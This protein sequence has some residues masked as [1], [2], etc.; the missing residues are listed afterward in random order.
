MKRFKFKLCKYCDSGNIKKRGFRKTKSD[1]V[2]VLGFKNC[3]KRF[4]ANFGFERM[5]NDSRTITLLQMYYQGMSCRGIECN[6]E[7]IGVDVDHS[8]I[9]NWICEYPTTV[10][11]YLDKIVPRTKWQ[12]YD[13]SR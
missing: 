6:F 2:K 11:K 1:K 8:A 12:K 3:K 13:E 5:K 4:T 10:S 9:Y 7:M